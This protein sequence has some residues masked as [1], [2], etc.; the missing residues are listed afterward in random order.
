MATWPTQPL[1]FINEHATS[2]SSLLTFKQ[3]IIDAV[4][5]KFAITLVQEP[6]LLPQL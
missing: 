6:E 3:K 1:V 2:T 5:T 4:Q